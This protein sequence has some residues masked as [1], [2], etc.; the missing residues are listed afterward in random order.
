MGMKTKSPQSLV[1]GLMWLRQHV[2]YRDNLSIRHACDQ[3]KKLFF[4]TKTT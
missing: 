1:T 2:Q 3:G 4:L